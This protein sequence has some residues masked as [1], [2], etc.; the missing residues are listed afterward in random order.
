MADCHVRGKPIG[1]GHES[2]LVWHTGG[3][4]CDLG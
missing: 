2:W 1:G 3:D 4:G